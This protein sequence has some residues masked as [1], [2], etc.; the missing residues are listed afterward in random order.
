MICRGPW[1]HH[2]TV[3]RLYYAPDDYTVLGTGPHKVATMHG[4]ET[5]RAMIKWV[6]SPYP[7][8][9]THGLG[10]GR[11]LSPVSN[12]RKR[13][14]AYTTADTPGLPFKCRKP[15]QRLSSA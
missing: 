7:H 12:L 10:V 15:V 4:T 6:I 9:A 3:A 14:R 13:Q 5:N 1:W 11:V 8:H 2:Y